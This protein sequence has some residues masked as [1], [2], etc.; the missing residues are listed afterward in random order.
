MEEKPSA[1]NNEEIPVERGRYLK[2]KQQERSTS[3]GHHHRSRI[4]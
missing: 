1:S 3:P 4:A 2:H